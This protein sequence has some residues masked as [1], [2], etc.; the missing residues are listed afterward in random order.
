MDKNNEEKK[1]SLILPVNGRLVPV[2]TI[3]LNNG[4]KFPTE[5]RCNL[6]I[7]DSPTRYFVTEE[8]YKRF[9]SAVLQILQTLPPAIE[10]LCGRGSYVVEVRDREEME[11]MNRTAEAVRFVK[12]EQT[13]ASVLPAFYGD[14]MKYMAVE[15]QKAAELE[16]IS[17]SLQKLML[18][19]ARTDRFGIFNTV[20]DE[21][22]LA[23]CFIEM[24]QKL[25]GMNRKLT[26]DCDDVTFAGYLFVLAEKLNMGGGIFS[27]NSRLK[28]FDFIQ[29]KVLLCIGVDVHTF[30]RRL[31]TM[32]I[33]KKAP[34][35]ENEKRELMENEHYKNFQ[36]VKK[37]FQQ[38]PFGA[39]Y[40]RI[41]GLKSK[42][43]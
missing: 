12:S 29:T 33:L 37:A 21:E 9:L 17:T 6:H 19:N 43:K 26:L 10:T 15:K 39:D 30:Y 20:I 23:T 24:H 16:T 31:N 2:K 3:K 40:L 38:C 34:S 28:F 27:C 14:C 18:A 7:P 41:M 36:K 42:K 11:G 5:M 32:K 13:A 22:N 4:D 25:Y 35:N 1:G 8:Q